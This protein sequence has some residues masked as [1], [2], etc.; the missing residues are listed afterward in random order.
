MVENF[1]VKENLIVEEM[2]LLIFEGCQVVLAGKM[3]HLLHLAQERNLLAEKIELIW[4][5]YPRPRQ[6]FLEDLFEPGHPLHE[7]G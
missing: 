7:T 5:L 1:E 2:E 6:D 4:M 3:M